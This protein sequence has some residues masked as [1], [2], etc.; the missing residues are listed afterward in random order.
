MSDQNLHRPKLPT[1]LGECKLSYASPNPTVQN[2]LYIIL[3][4][5]SETQISTAK[6][7]PRLADTGRYQTRT[8]SEVGV[9]DY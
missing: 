3:V 5:S 8:Q 6:S 9:P 1:L 2:L 7:C 4:K